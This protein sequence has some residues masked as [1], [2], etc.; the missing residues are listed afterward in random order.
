MLEDDFTYVVRKALKG[1]ALSPGEAAL[2]AGLVPA[3]VTALID[4]RFSGSVARKLAPALGLDPAALE[5]H[6]GY[7]P[8]PQLLHTLRRLD[9]PFEDG[10]VNA[11]LLR[12]DDVTLLFDTGFSPDSCARALDAVQAFEIDATFIT[13]GHRDHTG[14]LPEIRKRS[15]EIYG[16]AH[17][18]LPGVKPLRPGDSIRTGALTIHAFDLAGHCAGALGYRIEGLTRPVCVVGDA[19]FAG[20]IG[21]C[22]GPDTYATALN[23]LREG[24]MNL[25]DRTLLLPG[26]GPATTAGEERKGNPFLA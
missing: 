10:Q 24:V 7:A 22:T 5:G 11:W 2:R 14:G 13:H 18:S 4:G 15:R 19:L 20:S 25:P 9:I 17:D 3:E 1:L 8:K 16:P 6:P 12:E 26:H 21:G 23:N